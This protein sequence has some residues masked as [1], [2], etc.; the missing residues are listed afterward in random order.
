MRIIIAGG[1]DFN[2]YD[3]LE[4]ECHFIFHK[5]AKEGLLIGNVTK[6]I[7]NME[8]VS[9]AARGTDKLGEMFAN[10]YKIKIKQF[11]PDWNIGKQA[12]YI[13]NRDMAIYAKEDNGVLIAFWDKKSKGTNHMIN[14]ATSHG[15]RVFV[16][17][18]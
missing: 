12:G 8:I 1:R 2:D 11:I 9:G 16:F 15:L 18:Y 17:N 4:K 3:T 7:E 5:L 6:D 14:L 13:R 10:Q